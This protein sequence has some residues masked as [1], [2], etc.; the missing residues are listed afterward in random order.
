ME[1]R[2]GKGQDIIPEIIVYKTVYMQ[3]FTNLTTNLYREVFVVLYFG[4]GKQPAIGHI[5]RIAFGLRG[6]SWKENEGWR[7]FA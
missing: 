5:E 2:R 4:N 3:N 7:N 6:G 1:G